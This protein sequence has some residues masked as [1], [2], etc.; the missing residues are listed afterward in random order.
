MDHPPFALPSRCHLIPTLQ[1][2]AQA[3]KFGLVFLL[4]FQFP[5]IYFFVVPLSYIFTKNL[6]WV[7]YDF[8]FHMFL[9]NYRI[10]LVGW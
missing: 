1:Q 7:P 10:G 8:L 6:N 5:L 3:R 9:S 4:N 2:A